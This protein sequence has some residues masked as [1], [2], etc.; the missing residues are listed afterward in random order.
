MVRAET[1]LSD[2]T[3]AS[4]GLTNGASISENPSW[5]ALAKARACLEVALEENE[6]WR[7]LQQLEVREKTGE[8]LDVME[9]DELRRRLTRELA[10]EP[11][12]IAWQ[13][14]D[15]AMACLKAAV[16]THQSLGAGITTVLRETPQKDTD[17][18]DDTVEQSVPLEVPSSSIAM[19]SP[20]ASASA[21][22]ATEPLS[23]ARALSLRIPTLRPHDLKAQEPKPQPPPLPPSSLITT[24]LTTHAPARTQ[25]VETADEST[26][27][28]VKAVGVD[29]AEV[30]IVRHGAPAPTILNPRLP[31][32]LLS[33]RPV[34]AQSRPSRAPV[35]KW[36]DNDD[37]PDDYRPV[38]SALDEAQVT[39]ISSRDQNEARARAERRALG[40]APDREVQMR[41]FL[42]ALSGE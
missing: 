2:L 30:R 14:V 28:D 16:C 25:R 41:R 29:E 34:P 24:A 17:V 37:V 26:L 35:A 15:A 7:A 9:S 19:A 33:D 13:F 32:L 10:A 5:V 39:I 22:G 38:G 40:I 11:D 12:F 21:P 31:P 18:A 23:Q 36:T 42:K 1:D 27:F 8:W 6:A 3:H 4:E 20:T